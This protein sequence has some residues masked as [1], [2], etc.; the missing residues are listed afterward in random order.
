MISVVELAFGGLA[1]P[2][3]AVHLAFAGMAPVN[4]EVIHPPTTFYGGTSYLPQART[5]RNDDDEVLLLIA[6]ALQVME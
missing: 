3:L 5:R 1:P 6:M 2:I 4:A